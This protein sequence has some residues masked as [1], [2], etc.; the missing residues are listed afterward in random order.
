MAEAMSKLNVRYFAGTAGSSAAD[1]MEMPGFKLW[2]EVTGGFLPG[3]IQSMTTAKEPG[4]VSLEIV[5]TKR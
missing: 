5:L 4:N 2:N 3:Y 1:L